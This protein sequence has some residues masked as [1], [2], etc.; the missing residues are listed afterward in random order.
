MNRTIV[1]EHIPKRHLDF[2]NPILTD[3]VFDNTS[4]RIYGE[5]QVQPMLTE[6]YHIGKSFNPAD[7][8]PKIGERTKRLEAEIAQKVHEEFME[9]E[10][11]LAAQKEIRYFETTHKAVHVPLDYKANVIGRKV[12]VT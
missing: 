2:E 5:K 8:L 7:S 3:K 9:N 12:M 10:K 4:N 11:R 6:T 1:K